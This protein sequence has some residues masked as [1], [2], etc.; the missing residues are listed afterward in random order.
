MLSSCST[1]GVCLHK[2]MKR[3]IANAI[4]N[5][6][7]FYHSICISLNRHFIKPSP[8]F[9]LN[10]ASGTIC[11]ESCDIICSII[12]QVRNQGDLTGCP[13][14][15]VYAVVMTAIT[16][17]NTS[18]LYFLLAFY[19]A[20]LGQECGFTDSKQTL[21]ATLIL[22]YPS[23]SRSLKSAPTSIASRKRYR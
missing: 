10:K 15:L 14:I 21:K 19:F 17:A 23:F 12:R 16:I 6:R 5:N 13:L 20:R 7:L 1:Y 11:A 8:G 2:A 4:F 18:G 9:P 22:V 3:M